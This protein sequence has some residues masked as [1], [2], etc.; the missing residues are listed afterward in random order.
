MANANV[1]AE[2]L[3]FAVDMVCFFM[4]KHYPRFEFELDTDIANV[5]DNFRPH[6]RHHFSENLI[7]IIDEIDQ[8]QGFIV[9][10]DFSEMQRNKAEI[11]L[12]TLMEYFDSFKNANLAERFSVGNFLLFC[13]RV[14]LISCFLVVSGRKSDLN[15][16]INII[17]DSFPKDEDECRLLWNEIDNTAENY[18]S[19]SQGD[20][21]S[22]IFGREPS[23]LVDKVSNETEDNKKSNT[24]G[25]AT[26]SLFGR[27][28]RESA[29][30]ISN[31]TEGSNRSNSQDA[32]F[33]NERREF[34]DVISSGTEDSC[35]SSSNTNTESDS[36]ANTQN[37]SSASSDESL[38]RL[39]L[40][41]NRMVAPA[42]AR[43]VPVTHCC[44]LEAVLPA[45]APFA[46]TA[47]PF[48][49]APFAS[50]DAPSESAPSVAADAVSPAGAT[51]APSAVAPTTDVLSAAADADSSRA[52]TVP[53]AAATS[54]TGYVKYDESKQSDITT[55]TVSSTESVKCVKSKQSTT[56]V[57]ASS[58]ET[59]TY[60]E[61][62]ISA[63]QAVSDENLDSNIQNPSVSSS[64]SNKCPKI[65]IDFKTKFENAFMEVEAESTQKSPVKSPL[66][67]CLGKRP[68]PRKAK[69]S[70]SEETGED[71]SETE[72]KKPKLGSPESK[73]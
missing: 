36:S 6:V 52:L 71:D 41:L 54:N 32:V 38:N 63:T 64:T 19:N 35:S 68:S 30:A 51:A 60:V 48:A 73:D 42:A 45:A 4:K 33:D 21:T 39:I 65:E 11:D 47:A 2:K 46:D 69:V 10:R 53:S 62:K 40:K 26:S 61:S 29:D 14:S 56:V 70:F 72:I 27:E 20:A 34:V 15:Y 17:K 59:V 31:E 8:T 44:R 50:A 3:V 24:Q 13:A 22:A 7:K 55:A 5:V 25:N 28:A 67:S 12:S 58:T 16:M 9:Q 57:V 49:A 1:D 43:A 37:M 18:G 66:K 23:E